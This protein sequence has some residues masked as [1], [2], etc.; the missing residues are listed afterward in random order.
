MTEATHQTEKLEFK[1]ELKQLLHLITHSLYSNKEIFLREL[2]SN[3]SD[4]INKIKFDSL[5]HE[6][7]LEGNKDWKIKI[8]PDREAGTLTVSDNGI[9]MSRDSIVENLGTIAKSGTR[10]FLENL[11]NKEL[12]EKP[13][14][15]GQF[16]VGFYS[17]FMVADRVTVLSR[18]AGEPRD[19]VR[20]ESDGQGEFTVENIDKPARGTEVIL[21]LKPE[22]QGFL[23]PYCLQQIVKKFSDF[24]EHPVVMDVEKTDDNKNKT[25]V[26]ETLNARKAIWLRSKSENTAE[27]YNTFY[28]QIAGDIEDP[29]K[30]IHYTAEGINQFKVLLYV[31]AHRPFELQWGGEVKFGPKLYIQRVLIM[32]H[33]EALLP[34]YL[35]FIKGVVDCSDLPLNI[36]REMLQHN[37]LLEKIK[38]NLVRSVLKALEEMKTDEEEKYRKLHRELGAILKEGLS[39]DWSNR[40]KIADLLLF[41]SLKTPAGEYTTLEKYVE[42]MPADQKAIWYLIGESREMLEHSPYLETFRARGQDVLLLTDPI[43][44]FAL[45]SLGKYKD[46]ELKGVDRDEPEESKEEAGKKTEMQEQ[47]KQL[48]DYLRGKLPE[49]SDIRLSSRLKD[50]AACLVAGSGSMSAHLERLMQ[51]MGRAEEMEPARRIL[52]LNGEHPA[53]RALQQL[54]EKDAQDPRV[55]SY[56][57]LLYDQAV[58]AEGSRIKDPASFAQRINEM[59]VQSVQS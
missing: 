33:C 16:G 46:R 44:E 55:E 50:S 42:A 54:Y 36:S 37:P 13:E 18:M 39:R 22:E 38:S 29:A 48:F 14:L 21:H 4:A 47:F 6:E 31:P 34:P 8:I 25:L 56:A 26:E 43:D 41:E 19:G 53:V 24:I 17:A 7:K 32:D 11:Q 23:D 40:E 27:E 20:W 52:E 10:A 5:A 51:R 58:I 2:I 57:R 1:A 28:K 45:P 49:V 35:R 15:I 59:L 30:V 3:A 12:R 9:G